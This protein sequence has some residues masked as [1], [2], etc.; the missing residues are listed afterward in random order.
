MPIFL[1]IAFGNLLKN[2]RTSLTI[3]IV[4][5]VCVFLMEFGVGFIDGFRSKIIKDFLKEAGHIKIYNSSYYK[6]LDFSRTEFNIPYDTKMLDK[7][8]AV[9]GVQNVIPELNFGA[10]ANSVN[11]NIECLVKAVDLHDIE[12]NYTRREKMMIEGH[13][14]QGEKDIVLGYKAAKYLHVKLGDSIILLSV[15]QYGGIN[16]AEGRL[17]GLSKTN[18]SLEDE[19]LV[20]CAL[21]LAQKLLALEG[22]VTEI[23]VNIEDPMEAP[24]KAGVIQKILPTGT[25][26]VPWQVG[27]AFIVS[28][29]KIL[30]VVVVILSIIIIFAAS[31]GILNSFLMNILN[32]M[33]EFGVLRAM[34]VGKG[35]IFGMILTES[36]ML[37]VIGTIAGLIPGTLVVKYLEANPF[38]YQNIMKLMEGSTM[39]AIDASIGFLLIPASLVVILF[40]GVLISVVASLYPAVLAAVKKPSEIMRVLE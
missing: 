22:K 8:K 26:A 39:G 27:Q 13:F 10:I 29:L 11:E 15:D 12:K 20:V 16:A 24:I 21:P 31:L 19:S 2:R 37:G 23:T 18:S 17:V 33:Q 1:K 34:G 38:N 32:R 30:D 6:D 40:T 7:L 36:F 25:I 3:L 5:F 14:I 28:Y 35:Q 9:S 4:V